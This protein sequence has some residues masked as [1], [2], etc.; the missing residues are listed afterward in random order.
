[1]AR[2]LTIPTSIHEDSDSVPGLAQWV[3][4]PVLLCVSCDVGH[5]CGSGH[6]LLWLWRRLAA[7]A[8]IRPLAWESPYTVDAALKKNKKNS[9][10]LL[11]LNSQS[12]P[13]PLSNHRSV[14]L[15]HG[16]VSVS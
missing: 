11:T 12:I 7:A 8:L 15:V 5:R 16:S 10:H 9:L 1:M 14:V 13:L 6:T 2:Q 4:D 3:Q